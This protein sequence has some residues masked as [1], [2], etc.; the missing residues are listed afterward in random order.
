MGWRAAACALMLAVC[1][2]ANTDGALTPVAAGAAGTDT[3]DML[4]ATTRAPSDRPGVIFNGERGAGL[5]FANIV[6]SIPPERAPGTIQWPQQGRAD[7]ARDFAVTTLTPVPR[8]GVLDWF[9]NVTDGK[10]RRRVLIFVHGFNTR[11]DS[12]VFRFAQIVHDTH[13]DIAPVLFSW[14]SR[15]Q[16]F[17]YV[18][19]RES[20]NYSRDDL[21]YVMRTAARSPY[22]SEVVV[23]AHSMG[24]WL[25]VESLR[26][27]ALQDGRVPAKISNVIL[28]SPDLDLDVFRR[29]VM[30]MGKDRPRITI[31]VSRTDKA[32]EVSRFIAGGVTR[33][34]A[35][36]LTQPENLAQLEV[37]QGIVAVDLSALQNGDALNHSKFATSPDVVQLLGDRLR[38][39]Q[40]IEGAQPTGGAEA[41]QMVG[42]TV[43]SVA[44]API[45][46]FTGGA[47][48]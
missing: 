32:L 14:P 47:G 37:A 27:L 15:G 44:A 13:A 45:L 36:D 17:D 42:A 34:G 29:Q 39:G 10:A 8:S 46:I 21:A 28:A 23:M 41:A 22:V 35:V 38:A 7:P 18:Y 3:V 25:T 24:A 19:D 12:A 26:Q 4:V 9:K 5:S 33:V 48:N 30:E 16:V 11:F 43:G 40:E 2:C 31:F 1:G 20:T 6:V